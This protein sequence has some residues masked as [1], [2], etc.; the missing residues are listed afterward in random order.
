MHQS[1]EGRSTAAVKNNHSNL[2]YYVEKTFTARSNVTRLSAKTETVGNSSNAYGRSVKNIFA[3]RYG[4]T[5][6]P[7]RL[8]AKCAYAAKQNL[9]SENDQLPMCKPPYLCHFG[10]VHAWRAGSLDKGFDTLR[11][12]H[13]HHYS[14]YSDAPPA[15]RR[16]SVKSN[17]LRVAQ[18]HKY[19]TTYF[20][21][22]N[23]RSLHCAGQVREPIIDDI[24]TRRQGKARIKAPVNVK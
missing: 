4:P 9:R 17:A 13:W 2:S 18:A 23:N 16:P 15:V 3:Y 19:S 12:N 6:N 10:P 8:A 21:G 22:R 24:S 7:S 20:H 14:A 5:F 1:V 11:K